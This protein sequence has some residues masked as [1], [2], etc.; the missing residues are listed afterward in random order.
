MNELRPCP[1]CA[2]Q[3]IQLY[4]LPNDGNWQRNWSI[5]CNDCLCEGPVGITEQEAI[6][7]WNKRKVIIRDKVCELLERKG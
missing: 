6:D 1:F 5:A 3:D 7:G 2:R 4:E